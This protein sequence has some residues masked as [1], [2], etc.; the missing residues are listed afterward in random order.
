MRPNWTSAM[1]PA[2]SGMFPPQERKKGQQQLRQLSAHDVPVVSDCKQARAGLLGLHFSIPYHP[3]WDWVSE[4]V[5][6][7]SRPYLLPS[8]RVAISPPACHKKLMT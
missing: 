7:D 1:E 2:S 4:W 6:L 5:P 8:R 3:V